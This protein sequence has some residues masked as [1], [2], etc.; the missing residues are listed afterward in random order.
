MM[1]FRVD[2]SEDRIALGT[3][4][5]VWKWQAMEKVAREDWERRLLAELQMQRK[6]EEQ[7]DFCKLCRGHQSMPYSYPH[8][9]DLSLQRSITMST[10]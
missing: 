7:H 6:A 8:I 3:H 5:H 2:A 9:T 10:M 4:L 1:R